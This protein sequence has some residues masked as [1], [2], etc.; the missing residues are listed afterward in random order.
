MPHPDYDRFQAE[1]F[2]MDDYF[3]EW[4]LRPSP[5]VCS[6]WEDFMRKNSAGTEELQKAIHLY[7]VLKR[8]RDVLTDSEARVLKQ[9]IFNQFHRRRGAQNIFNAWMS[10]AAVVLVIAVSLFTYRFLRPDQIV[11]ET[12]YGVMQKVSLPDATVVTLNGN[13]SL[14]YADDFMA[15]STREVWLEGEAF[16]EVTESK[17]KE[18][19][20]HADDLDVEVLGTTFNVDNSERVTRVVL[21]TGSV[22]VT[23]HAEEGREKVHLSPGEMIAYQKTEGRM[24][25]Q[26][27]DPAAYASWK[28][29]AFHFDRISV[30][31]IAQT[32]EERYGYH[33]TVA[34]PALRKKLF[35]ARLDSADVDVLVAAMEK[36]LSMRAVREGEKTMIW[37]LN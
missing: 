23:L 22:T 2:L 36:A 35:T 10:A 34:D 11:V 12:A 15:A 9:N 3:M 28:N 27:V 20:V 31:D 19:I 24:V 37:S 29:A 18:F 8:D 1:D 4:M 6:F 33:V 7:N 26:A 30:E 14:R 16:F 25:K 17:S 13:S 32:L 21:N 5:R